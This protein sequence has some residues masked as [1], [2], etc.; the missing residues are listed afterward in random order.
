MNLLESKLLFIFLIITIINGKIVNWKRPM[1]LEEKKNV[2]ERI[3]RLDKVKQKICNKCYPNYDPNFKSNIWN[4]FFKKKLWGI[5]QTTTEENEIVEYFIKMYTDGSNYYDQMQDLAKNSYFQDY[6][7]NV[8][9]K[10][11]YKGN[12]EINYD[13][14]ELPDDLCPPNFW[15]NSWGMH[16]DNLQDNILALQTMVVISY[17]IE[18][19]NKE[20]DQ[21]KILYR[22]HENTNWEQLFQESKIV[23]F[24]RFLSTS[25]SKFLDAYKFWSRQI[26][27]TINIPPGIP[28]G[29]DVDKYSS[30]E[31]REVLIPPGTFFRITKVEKKIRLSREIVE[32]ELTCLAVKKVL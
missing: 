28:C 32:I 6:F 17:L 20:I 1:S 5:C 31:E 3:K 4:E 22:K 24:N 14:W 7:S 16:L 19:E 18:N 12:S 13:D 2:L 10:N 11:A 21:R 29:M 15:L 27:I 26:Y 23:Q 9:G 30:Y 8:P 25:R